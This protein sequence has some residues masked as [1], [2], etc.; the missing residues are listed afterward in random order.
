MNFEILIFRKR[1]PSFFWTMVFGIVFII[2]LFPVSGFAWS[3]ID[4]MAICTAGNNQEFP[5][6]TSDGCGGTIIVWQDSRNGN[7]AIYAQRVAIILNTVG[8]NPF[9]QETTVWTLGGITICTAG[10]SQSVPQVVSDGQG[11]AIIAWQDNRFSSD[12]DI[13]M[14]RVNAVGSTLWS[15]N[16][17]AVCTAGNSQTSPKLVSDGQGGAIITWE[18]YRIGTADLYAQRVDATG[19]VLWTVNGVAVCTAGNNQYLPQLVADSQG[20][21]II[22]W[23]DYRSGTNYDIYAQRVNSVGVTLWAVNGITVCTAGNYQLSPQLVSDSQSGTIITWFDNRSGLDYSIYAQR[24]NSQG[25]TLW[26]VNGIAVCTAG[27]NQMS[28]QLVSDGQGGAIITWA[29]LR[30][31]AQNIYAQRVDAIGLTLWPVNGIAVCTAG[32]GQGAQQLV[33]DGQGGAII[34]WGDYRS[35]TNS[36][37]YAQQIDFAVTTTTHYYWPQVNGGVSI[38]TA[39]NNQCEP[40]VLAD[41]QGGAIITWLDSR[42]TTDE[43]YAQRVNSEGS[44]LWIF[45]SVAIGSTTINILGDLQLVADGQG[46]AIITWVGYRI[47]SEENIYA[48]RINSQGSTLWVLNGIEVCTAADGQHYPISISDEQGGAIITWHDFRSGT[49]EDIYAQ[50]VNAQGSTLWTIN[51]IAICTAKDR[52]LYP[53]LIS[54]GAGGAIITWQDS[55]NTTGNPEQGTDIYAQRVNSFGTPLWA[56]NGVAVCTAT[57]WQDYPQL[58][59]DGQGGAIIFWEDYRNE[60]GKTDIYAQRINTQGSTLWSVTGIAISTAGNNQSNMQLVADGQGGAIITW[61]DYRR[62]SFDIYAQRVNVQGSTLWTLNGVA[63]STVKFAQGQAQLVSDGQGG[64]IITWED[65]RSDISY[66]IY[67]QR[68]DPFGSVLWYTDGYAI[69]TVS[70]GQRYPQLVSDGQGGAIITWEDYRSGTNDDIYAQRIYPSGWVGAPPN[71]VPVELS[72]FEA[73][74]GIKNEK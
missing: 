26:S 19:N 52:Q 14:Q 38:C 20:G 29:D 9:I 24:V 43:V 68:I 60:W 15:V 64:V 55:R 17:V 32:N 57:S 59:A 4:G 53:Q 12:T 23:Q 39:G 50:R 5:Q 48:Q 1:V 70:G 22:T 66:D 73:F 56:I 2:G 37:I 40:Q 11:G 21:A 27:N 45:N 25:S 7:S 44:T 16:G 31:G 28:P 8:S 72:R 49:D 74:E 10:N 69:C 30:S 71:M 13:Y 42:N 67:A 65:Y 41:G 62:G 6:L 54:D 47:D 35:E 3:V 46:G 51:G 18:D 36:D 58:V 33:A 63:I 34:T 61:T